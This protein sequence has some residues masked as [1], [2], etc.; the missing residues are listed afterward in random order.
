MNAMPVQVPISTRRFIVLAVVA[1]VSLGTFVLSSLASLNQNDFMYAVAPA[2]W[3]QNGALYTDVPYPQA[4]L[5]ILLNSSLA[6][7][8]RNVNIF[9]P[10]R[11]LSMVLVLLAVLLPVLNRT[12]MRNIE[13]WILY[14]ALCLTNFFV[15]SNSREIGNYALSLLCLSAAITVVMSRGSATWRGFAAFAFLG[16]ATSAKLYFV[17]LFP[18]LL[19]F[20]LINDRKGREF[21]VIVTCVLGL[22]LGLAPV[23][24]FLA[25]DHQAFWQ[26]TIRFFQLIMPFRLAGAAD[27]FRQTVHM[28]VLFAT[29]MAIPLGFLVVAMWNAWRRGD[30]DLREKSAQLLLLAGASAMAVSPIILFGQYFGPLAFLLLL[31]SAPWNL[32]DGQTRFLYRVFAGALLCIQCIVMAAIIGPDISRDA[33]VAVAEVLKVQTSARTLV[34]NGYHCERRLYTTVP[35]FLLE[36]D[37]KY[38]SELAAG[39]FLMFFLR[40]AA[41]VQK[42]EAFDLDAHIKKWNPDIVIWGYFLGSHDAA[43]DEVDRSIR[44]YAVGRNFVIASIGNVDGHDIKFAYRAGCRDA[45]KR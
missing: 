7:I 3:A 39:P 9:L 21:A 2:V 34:Q 17:V 22:L 31:F 30:D 24:F 36:N 14:V 37:I 25:R 5:S 6:A 19:L 1:M 11:I 12:R 15:V 27:A 20:F 29:L 40:G 42:R 33:S 28:L 44:D 13:I 4:P 35:L 23:L 41:L 45:L 32:P 38:P 26:W 16:L 10:A 43:E 8:G 18:A